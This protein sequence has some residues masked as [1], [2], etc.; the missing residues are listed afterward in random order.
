MQCTV[1]PAVTVLLTETAGQVHALVP[2]GTKDGIAS[3]HD[4]SS[5]SEELNDE[6]AVVRGPVAPP[7]DGEVPV[8]DLDGHPLTDQQPALGCPYPRSLWL[9]RLSIGHR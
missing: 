9:T 7:V 3:S 5:D 2:F 8:H 4:D 6:A 1:L